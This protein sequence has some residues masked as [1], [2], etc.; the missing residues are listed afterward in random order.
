MDPLYV[1]A[2]VFR[3][4][5]LRA[6]QYDAIASAYNMLRFFEMKRQIFGVKKLVKDITLEDLD[7]DDI[8]ALKTGYFQLAG[9]DRSGR[10]LNINFP[11]LRGN[12]ALQNELRMRYY[13]VMSA[14]ENEEFQLSKNVAVVFS[15]GDM[16]D[17]FDGKGFFETTTFSFALP[18]CKASIHLCTDE[19]GAYL[20]QGAILKGVPLNIRSRCRLHFGSQTECLYHLS[21]FGIPPDVLPVDPSTDKISLK[22]HLEWVESRYV[23]EKHRRTLPTIV[24]SK[25]QNIMNAGDNDVLVGTGKPSNNMGNKRLR[26]FVK[27]WSQAYGNGT[28]EARKELVDCVTISIRQ[29]GGRFLKEHT[30]DGWKTFWKEMPEDQIRKNVS[31]AFRNSYRRRKG[32]GG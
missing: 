3:V 4:M 24:T 31:Q 23:I 22:R 32:N 19:V 28:K 16:K 20:I 5:F 6:N 1:R 11:G 30:V 2:R 10:T 13:I 29:S 25:R 8:A 7:E 26:S 12:M 18:Q 15:V 9:K 14:L 27:E 17:R 21:T